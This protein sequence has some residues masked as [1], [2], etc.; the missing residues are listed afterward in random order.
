VHYLA[1]DLLVGSWIIQDARKC[2]INHLYC[3][4]FLLMTFMIGPVGYFAY[5]LLRTGK[6]KKMEELFAHL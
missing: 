3:I 5:W 2:R 4:P 6:R 1:F